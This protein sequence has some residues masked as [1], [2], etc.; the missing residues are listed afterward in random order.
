[1]NGVNKATILGTL[2]RDPEERTTQAGTRVVSFSVAT[3][4]RWTAQSGEKKERTE[5]HRIVCFNENLGKVIT[6]FCKK[7]SKVYLEGTI[8]KRKYTDKSGVEREVSEIVLPQFNSRLELIGDPPSQSRDAGRGE[9]SNDYDSG[10]GY[11][12]AQP[13]FPRQRA[14][15]GAK[16]RNDSNFPAGDQD[17]DDEIPF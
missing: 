8:Q 4:E 6:K 7:G 15:E 12:G 10:R 5:W 14:P 1:M 11:G 3:S 16:L 13:A 9:A 2:G 17:L